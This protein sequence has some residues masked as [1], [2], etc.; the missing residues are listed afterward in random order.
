MKIGDYNEF[1]G[2]GNLYVEKNIIAQSLHANQHGITISANNSTNNLSIFY[3]AIANGID[4]PLENIIYPA[5]NVVSS[6]F[7]NLNLLNVIAI[8]NDSDRANRFV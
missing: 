5:I 3:S 8:N 2:F 4:D 1:M 7:D 6:S